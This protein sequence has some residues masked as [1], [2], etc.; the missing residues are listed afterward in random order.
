MPTEA[1]A[2]SE[3]GAATF[4]LFWVN[5]SHYASISGDYEA[6]ARISDPEC[7][8]CSKLIDVY[9]ETW[10]NGGSFS[11]GEQTLSDVT[12]ERS[13]DGRAVLVRA[14]STIAPGT[15][16]ETRSAAPQPVAR[17]VTRVSYRVER[18]DGAWTMTEFALD[19]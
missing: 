1:Q 9:R 7:V 11:G 6:L 5:T 8:S 12:A 18:L 3:S 17:E 16:A 19:D 4:V 15:Y 10:E 2:N 13:A 14:E